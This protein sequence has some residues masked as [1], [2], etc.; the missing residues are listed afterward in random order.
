MSRE[1]NI[2]AQLRM[3]EAVNAGDLEVLHE[4]FAADVIDHDAADDQGKGP[5]GFVKFFR[6]FRSAF[7]DLKVNIEHMT[8]EGDCIAIAV[9]VH[10]THLGPHMGV[11]PTGRTIDVRG[12]Q[13]ARF[14]DRAQIKERWGS[15][16]ELTMLRQIRA[17]GGFPSA[18]S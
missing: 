9:R 18:T 10:G 12:L 16:D 3:I 15:S 8:A 14:N 5:A 2:A 4:I 1:A 13:I 6:D 7:P 17:L 11:P